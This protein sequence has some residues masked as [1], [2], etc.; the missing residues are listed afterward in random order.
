M[1]DIDCVYMIY[2]EFDKKRVQKKFCGKSDMENQMWRIR[3][4]ESDVENQMWK[5]YPDFILPS[6]QFSIL[7]ITHKQFI[8][9]K[10]GFS[11]LGG[12]FLKFTL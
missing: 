4:G 5:N 2:G 6:I 8:F 12:S 7:H 3:C 10:N 1:D 11:F 9:L